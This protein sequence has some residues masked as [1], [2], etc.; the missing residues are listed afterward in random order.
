MSRLQGLLLRVSRSPL[1]FIASVLVFCLSFYGLFRI[2][3][4]F[5]AVTGGFQP[6]DMQNV[7]KVDG[8]LAQLPLYTD[9]S[10]RLYAAFAATDFVF[11]AVGG[12]V[13]GGAAA[14]LMRHGLPS[15]YVRFEARRGFVLFLL[16]TLF[17]F[18]ENVAALA[19]IFLAPPPSRALAT[20]LVGFHQLKLGTLLL[21][22]GTI[23]LL[24]LVLVLRKAVGL[25]RAPQAR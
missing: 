18:L 16:P 5:A 21:G 1:A 13:V 25:V 17:D 20:I 14:F 9:D 11:P 10:R 12:L 3:D 19:V 4:A 2:T 15:V 7:L 24:A 6:F 23:M 8:V 22:H